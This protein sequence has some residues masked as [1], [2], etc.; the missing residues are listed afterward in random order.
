MDER[1][2]VILEYFFYIDKLYFI[3]LKSVFIIFNFLKIFK[4]F[5]FLRVY[6]YDIIIDM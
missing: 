3:V 4:F 1:F 5:K 2:G 6:E